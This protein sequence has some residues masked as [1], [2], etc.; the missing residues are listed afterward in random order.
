MPSRRPS[1]RRLRA[2]LVASIT[3]ALESG[4]ASGTRVKQ[5]EQVEQVTEW[6][7][8]DRWQRCFSEECREREPLS[9]ERERD[10]ATAVF[11]LERTAC[12]GSCP[13]Y[14]VS[15]YPDGRV[16]YEGKDFVSACGRQVR[17]LPAAA[18]ATLVRA[19]QRERYLTSHMIE[20]RPDSI[21]PTD[22]DSAFTAVEIGGERRVVWH[23]GPHAA[24]TRLT[25]LED[26]ID[27]VAEVAPWTTCSGE[28]YC[29]HADPG[30]WLFSGAG[31]AGVPAAQNGRSSSVCGGPSSK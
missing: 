11:R 23:Y 13:A 7:S 6:R 27:E 18:H 21:R 2:V 28:C 4:C 10:W 3:A 15:V 5:V 9:P 31:D 19:F 8:P 1:P 29:K 30:E 26:L 20:E 24:P 14:R 22:M 17:Q 25:A 12:Y 16:E